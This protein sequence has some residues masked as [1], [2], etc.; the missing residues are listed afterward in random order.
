MSK[1]IIFAAIF[2]A[3][4]LLT[5]AQAVYYYPLTIQTFDSV[6]LKETG[7][8]KYD[9]VKKTV[10]TRGSVAQAFNFFW[11]GIFNPAIT[12]K[13]AAELALS[14]INPDGTLNNPDAFREAYAQYLQLKQ[15]FE[16]SQ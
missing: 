8:F 16:T 1:K 10:T 11:R 6:T 12:L 9:P 14:Y 15:Q 13:G 7:Y 3:A 2:A 4:G 5:R